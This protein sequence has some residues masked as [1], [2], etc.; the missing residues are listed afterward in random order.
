MDA[1]ECFAKM[2][3]GGCLA[4]DTGLHRNRCPGSQGCN[5]FRT[6]A[7][8]RTSE[9]AALDRIATLP[10]DEQMSIAEKYY[11]GKMPWMQ[12]NGR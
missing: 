11:G 1:F 3:R 4:I 2:P 10:D 6:C 7:E 8:M 9:N 12:M 5:F